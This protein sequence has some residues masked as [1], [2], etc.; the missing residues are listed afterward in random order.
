MYE[1]KR[2]P[3]APSRVFYRRLWKNFFLASFILFVCLLIG[4]AGYK[5]TVPEFDWY[6][7]LLNASMIL[8]GMGPVIDA[9]VHLTKTAKV[10]A[11]FYALFSGVAF[12]TNIGLLLTPIAHRFFHKL[13]LEED[14]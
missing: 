14:K 2:Q 13:N 7:S 6:D 3:L 12:I 9:D 8:S 4:V 5:L 10:F 1:H 11:S